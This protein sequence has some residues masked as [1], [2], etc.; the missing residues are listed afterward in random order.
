MFHNEPANLR[1]NIRD[2]AVGLGLLSAEFFI[3]YKNRDN[4]LL[5][6]CVLA[7]EKVLVSYHS[8]SFSCVAH[9]NS[10]LLKLR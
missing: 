5:S 10:I 2:K 9:A 4:P 3:P 6:M 7:L 8:D 1:I